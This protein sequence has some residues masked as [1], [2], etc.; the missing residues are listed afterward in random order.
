M[1]VETRFYL[2]CGCLFSVL[3]IM[4][5]ENVGAYISLEM[6]LAPYA[7]LWSSLRRTPNKGA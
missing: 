1:T 3:S 6:Q 5:R 7:S 4:G 2:V